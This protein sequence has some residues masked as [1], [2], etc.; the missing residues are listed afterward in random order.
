MHKKLLGKELMKNFSRLLAASTIALLGIDDQYSYSKGEK[1]FTGVSRYQLKRFMD[2]DWDENKTLEEIILTKNINW[3][4]GWIAIDDVLLEKPFA[5]KIEGVYW[6]YSSKTNKAEQGINVTVLSWSDGNQTIPIKFMVYEKDKDTGKAIKTK[7]K[8]AEESIQYCILKGIIPKFVCFDSKYPS[9]DLLN[10]LHKNGIIY[11]TQL[12]SNR[13]F[14]KEQL[15]KRK[16]DLQPEI[17][18]IRGVGHD[19]SVVKH[20]KRYYATNATRN[21][22]SRQQIL[23]NYKV[24]WSVEELFRALKQLCHIKECKSRTL[25]A[26]KKYIMI[27]LNAFIVLQNQQ[28][29]SVYEAKL[30]FQQ[31]FMGRKINGNKALKLLTA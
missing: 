12:P 20:C 28:K 8:F 6:L 5:E 15:K 3:S 19:V 16:F 22:V 26:Q 2:K 30:Y 7:N 25:K 29:G 18:K 11:Y 9:K 24:R 21:K 31:K 27:C 4:T 23:K 17:G 1:V 13:V 10:T 14:N